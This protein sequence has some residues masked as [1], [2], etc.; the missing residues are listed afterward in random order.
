MV[1]RT[2]F[3][4]PC[5]MIKLFPNFVPN[6]F[7]ENVSCVSR[8]IPQDYQNKT[9]RPSASLLVIFFSLM[10]ICAPIKRHPS[11]NNHNYKNLT[12]ALFCYQ[13]HLNIIKTESWF[14]ENFYQIL[15]LSLNLYFKYRWKHKRHL[16]I[17]LQLKNYLQI[18]ILY[19]HKSA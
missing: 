19:S 18:D 4:Y 12:I 11:E 13:N 10:K 8:G 16:K 1:Q 3:I 14:K 5:K 7:L 2:H 15:G 9:L 17:R 6:V